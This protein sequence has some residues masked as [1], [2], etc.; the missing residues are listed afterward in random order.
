VLNQRGFVSIENRI[1][2]LSN[3]TTAL[4]NRLSQEL[5]DVR[6]GLKQ[7]SQIQTGFDKR[8]S[9]TEDKLGIPPH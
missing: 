1:T 9:R 5:P 7:F 8:L 2:D 4:D 6:T 3:R